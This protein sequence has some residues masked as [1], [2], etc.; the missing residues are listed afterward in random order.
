MRGVLYRSALAS[1]QLYNVQTKA[2]ADQ[3]RGNDD[4]DDFYLEFFLDFFFFF[5]KNVREPIVADLET[6]P[7]IVRCLLFLSSTAHIINI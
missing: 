7:R 4:C 3:I 1:I 5:S 6:I 2:R